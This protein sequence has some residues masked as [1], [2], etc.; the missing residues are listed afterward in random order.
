M[1]RRAALPEKERERAREGRPRGGVAQQ[2]M[3]S[4]PGERGDEAGH[5]EMGMTDQGVSELDRVEDSWQEGDDGRS[6]EQRAPGAESGE[7]RTA[8]WRPEVSQEIPPERQGPDENRGDGGD[9]QRS[10][11]TLVAKAEERQHR[12]VRDEQRPKM[13][14]A[15][16]FRSARETEQRRQ[17]EKERKN[18]DRAGGEVGSSGSAGRRIDRRI[19]P[20]VERPGEDPGSGSEQKQQSSLRHQT[21]IRRLRR[22]PPADAVAGA[23]RAAETERQDAPQERQGRDP[24]SSHGSRP[25][26]EELAARPAGEQC[27]GAGAERAGPGRESDAAGSDSLRSRQIEPQQQADQR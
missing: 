23:E 4:Q 19:A 20:R 18:G 24:E 15:R 17:G 10:V 22:Q 26:E 21:C 14:R 16:R 13:A 5:R 7:P 9:L 27:D 11:V 2:G 12:R 25:I 8:A 3:K 1:E 6:R